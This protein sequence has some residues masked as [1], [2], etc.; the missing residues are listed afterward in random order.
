VRIKF[1]LDMS[2]LFSTHWQLSGRKLL[3]AERAKTQTGEYSSGL[4]GYELLFAECPSCE[5]Q[6]R[7]YREVPIF[8]SVSEDARGGYGSIIR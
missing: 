2:F 5:M 4:W 8:A 1:G 6:G 7:G 3:F